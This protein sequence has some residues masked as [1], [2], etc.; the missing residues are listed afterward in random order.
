MLFGLNSGLKH[1]VVRCAAVERSTMNQ[2][3]V[4]GPQVQFPVCLH[5]NVNVLPLLAE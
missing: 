3:T 2:Q 5:Q 4:D 1:G